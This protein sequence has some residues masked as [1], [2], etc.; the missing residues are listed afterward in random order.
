MLLRLQRPGES[1]DRTQQRV[2]IFRCVLPV[3]GTYEES[4]A[5]IRLVIARINERGQ[6]VIQVS[7]QRGHCRDR[8]S[9]G[10]I[11]AEVDHSVE[12]RDLTCN[13]V[14]HIRISFIWLNSPPELVSRLRHSALGQ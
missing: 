8:W 9:Q 14:F 1:V 11:R 6:D 3:S 7:Q 2:Y 5:A 13:D 10:M 12:G 4:T